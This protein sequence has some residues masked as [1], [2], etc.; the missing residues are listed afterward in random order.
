MNPCENF[1][2]RR[3]IR[4]VLMAIV[5]TAILI[6]GWYY[7]LLGYFIPLCMLSGMGIAF[8][9][10]RKW[11]DWYCPRGSFFDSVIKPVSPAKEI[12]AFF[13]KSPLRIAMFSFLMLMMTVQIIKR[14]PDPY[15]IGI[16]FIILLTATTILGVFLALIF[17]QR[18]WCCFCPIG[19]MGYWIGRN[20]YPL[21]IDSKLCTECQLCYKV[22]PIRIAPFAFK[23]AEVAVVKD[24]D[25]LKCR[26]CVEAC[27]QKALRF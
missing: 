8:F 26:L 23:K 16:F 20:K 1:V 25:C 15:K 18:T 7:P 27:P 22:C 14:W 2:R 13:K 12:P 17:H 9:K 21:K 6:A 19:S 11:C 10:G 4:Q 24:G 3:F 5:F